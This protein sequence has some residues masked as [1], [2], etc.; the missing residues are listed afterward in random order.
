[1]IGD[2]L[3]KDL[4]ATLLWL[5]RMKHGE[6]NDLMWGVFGATGTLGKPTTILTHPNGVGNQ[7][8]TLRR[9]LIGSKKH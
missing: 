5:F 9:L 6:K 2:R 1:M 3:Q 7:T 8:T 4:S